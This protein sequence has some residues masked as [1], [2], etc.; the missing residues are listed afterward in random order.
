MDLNTWRAAA[1]DNLARLAGTLRR[2]GPDT[3]YGALSAATLLPVITA[4]Q[5]ALAQSQLAQRQNQVAL[6]K[7]LGGGW[8][9]A[10]DGAAP[11][12]TQALAMA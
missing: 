3:V 6:Y 4:S 7:A 9:D 12:A 2:L 1:H 11:A 10:A 5:Q 8:R